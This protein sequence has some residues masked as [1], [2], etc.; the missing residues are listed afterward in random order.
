MSNHDDKLPEFSLDDLP[1]SDDDAALRN[2]S[3][4]SSE[5]IRA[6]KITPRAE[7][8]PPLRPDDYIKK[9]EPK[10]P[11]KPKKSGTW[12]YNLVSL[13]A[14]LGSIAVIAWFTSVWANPQTQLNPLAPP[15]PFLEVTVTQDVIIIV[16]TETPM[17]G[18][19]EATSAPLP[20]L[21]P[22]DFILAEDVRFQAS[23]TGLGCDAWSIGGTVQRPNGEGVNGLRVRIGGADVNETVFT[24][25]AERF[26]AGGFELTVIGAPKED[27]YTVQLT[28][29]QGSPLSDVLQIT[30]RASCDGNL[31]VI[32]FVEN[33]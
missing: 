4:L 21:S 19:A 24:G 15:T 26:G 3:N 32:N 2:L 7:R 5:E 20:T 25:T 14:L 30:T 33:S 8:Y 17:S 31:A 22:F 29:A 12:R 27:S 6:P 9:D 13:L 18:M 10:P 11:Y 28:S 16:A 23:T 1:D